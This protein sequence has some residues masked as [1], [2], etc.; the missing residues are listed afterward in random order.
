MLKPTASPGPSCWPNLGIYRAGV[1]HSPREAT[2][3]QAPS[4]GNPARWL[5]TVPLIL[6]A[7]TLRLCIISLQSSWHASFN[8]PSQPRPKPPWVPPLQF[9]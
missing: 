4:R 6:T 5:Q 3:L 7:K 8:I 9:L 2:S 1:L